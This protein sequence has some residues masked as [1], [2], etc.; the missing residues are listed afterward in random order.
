MSL[1]FDDLETPEQA[2]CARLTDVLVGNFMLMVER[3]MSENSEVK[4]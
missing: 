3:E 2:F 1:D 4:S